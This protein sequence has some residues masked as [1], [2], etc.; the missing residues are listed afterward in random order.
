MEKCA[1]CG[2]FLTETNI[3]LACEDAGLEREQLV[4]CCPSYEQIGQREVCSGYCEGDRDLP[5]YWRI[6]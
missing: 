5:A 2:G 3:I 1:N 6:A 4:F